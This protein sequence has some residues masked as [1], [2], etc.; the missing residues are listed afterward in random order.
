MKNPP[1]GVMPWR[2][3]RCLQL[4]ARFSGRIAGTQGDNAV[5]SSDGNQLV[6]AFPCKIFVVDILLILHHE[7]DFL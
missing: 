5:L 3:L 7:P 2:T 1:A 4:E 6:A